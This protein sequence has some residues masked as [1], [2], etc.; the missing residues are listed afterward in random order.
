M[1][2]E[3]ELLELLLL[4]ELEELLL[5]ARLETELKTGITTSSSSGFF[6][7]SMIVC[8]AGVI[9]GSVTGSCDSARSWTCGDVELLL[10]TLEEELLEEELL[11]LL[12][13]WMESGSSCCCSSSFF[14]V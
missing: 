5:P 3:K 4:L 11:E 12:P 9:S 13:A 8:I 1:M 2:L 7:N 10:L 14:E 6:R